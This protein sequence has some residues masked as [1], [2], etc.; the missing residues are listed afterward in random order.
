MEAD[1]LALAG[2]WMGWD[3]TGHCPDVPVRA[4]PGV[5]CLAADER[6]VRFV[7]RGVL[8]DL[9]V[10][11]LDSC[12]SCASLVDAAPWLSVCLGRLASVMLFREEKLQSAAGEDSRYRAQNAGK[13]AAV[14]QTAGGSSVASATCVVVVWSGLQVGM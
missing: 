9:A 10:A 8:P 4:L 7:R 14:A 13:S 1:G 11:V 5:P 2:M 6:R 3:G 12:C